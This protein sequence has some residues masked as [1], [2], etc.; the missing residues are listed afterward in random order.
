MR[1]FDFMTAPYVYLTEEKRDEILSRHLKD[2]GLTEEATRTIEHQLAD[3]LAQRRAIQLKL[4]GFKWSGREASAN[5]LVS[6]I[7]DEEAGLTRAMRAKAASIT[8][9]ADAWPR[10]LS[11]VDEARAALEGSDLSAAVFVGT[12]SRTYFRQ[13]VDDDLLV[14]KVTA[15]QFTQILRRRHEDNPAGPWH[16]DELHE[17]SDGYLT[18]EDEYGSYIWNRDDTASGLYAL[19]HYWAA[20]EIVR[21]LDL[22]DSACDAF[23]FTPRVVAGMGIRLSENQLPLAPL[24][25][26]E[27]QELLGTGRAATTAVAARLQ[28]DDNLR[29]AEVAH[30]VEDVEA[31]PWDTGNARKSVCALLDGE[32]ESRGLPR[33]KEIEDQID[34]RT[35]GLRTIYRRFAQTLEADADQGLPVRSVEDSPITIYTTPSCPGCKLTKDKLTEAGVDFRSVDLSKHPDLVEE[36]KAEGLQSA[37]IIE[38][39]DGQR[40]SGFRP[41]R[42]KAIIATAAVPLSVT[43]APDTA[44]KSSFSPARF[45]HPEQ[46]TERTQ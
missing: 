44:S 39:L 43:T 26:S 5:R 11:F 16:P 21:E 14:P 12:S 31:A 20:E 29:W 9:K 2:A 35:N 42:I 13:R 23:T 17:T 27:R 15:E 25:S 45:L 19:E 28:V 8:G 3:H 32:L 18:Y 6:C 30:L 37:P 7:N 1:T 10:Y 36:F 40:T 38:T 24:S 46:A 4:D 41:D 34:A 33:L 22:V